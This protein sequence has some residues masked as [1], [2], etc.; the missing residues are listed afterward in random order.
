MK[1]QAVSSKTKLLLVCAFVVA[2]IFNGLAGSTTILGGL[3]TA[4]VSDTYKNLFTPAGFTFAIWGVI[5]SLILVF[6]LYTCGIGRRK[7]SKV[8]PHTLTKIATLASINLTINTTWI[9]AWQHQIMWLSVILMLAL[10]TTLVL[11]VEETKKTKVS[12]IEYIQL[13]LPFSIYFGWITVAT[14]ANIAAWLVS[15]RWDGSGI[16][17]ATWMVII[18]LVA[19]TL[20]SYIALRNRDAA[21][22]AVFIWAFNGILSV[23]TSPSGY[24]GQYTEVTNTLIFSLVLL[25][26]VF[27]YLLQAK[28]SKSR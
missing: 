19:L 18:T 21:Y 4:G 6:V 10:L 5:Y 24:G 2:M 3:D 13:K 11:I 28:F 7:T 23:H 14:V 16:S 9:L 8:S 17:E 26:G 15:I 25:A 27:L 22:I 20:G 1:A 12:G